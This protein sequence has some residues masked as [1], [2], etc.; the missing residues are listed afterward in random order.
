VLLHDAS[1]GTMP[2]EV[3][4]EWVEGWIALCRERIGCRET[5]A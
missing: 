1:A 3:A 4:A 5:V 2:E